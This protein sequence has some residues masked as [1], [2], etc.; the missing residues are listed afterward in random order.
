M[1]NMKSQLSFTP[2]AEI[3]TRLLAVLA[4]SKIPSLVQVLTGATQFSWFDAAG[5][6]L[7]LLGFAAVAWVL[8]G[9]PGRQQAK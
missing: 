3:E 1:G 9:I 8:I 2:L 6:W 4:V 7:S 5:G